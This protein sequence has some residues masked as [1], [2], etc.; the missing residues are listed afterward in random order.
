MGR[1]KSYPLQ[2]LRRTDPVIQILTNDKKDFG[3]RFD[4]IDIPI[5]QRT[6]DIIKVS[7][8]PT[9]PTTFDPSIFGKLP[10]LGGQLLSE[11]KRTVAETENFTTRF[12]PSGTMSSRIPTKISTLNPVSKIT[13]GVSRLSTN[14]S[15][16]LN[17]NSVTKR[18]PA[19][20][21]NFILPFAKKKK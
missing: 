9:I 13:D 8:W 14:T 18:Q 2:P 15:R 1:D 7:S 11:R 16:T 10:N 20:V 5:D 19:Q 21:R 4:E 12:V 6:A 3:L 17:T